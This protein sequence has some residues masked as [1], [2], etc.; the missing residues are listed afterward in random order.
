[1]KTSHISG[2][3]RSRPLNIIT[4]A[5]FSALIL[6]GCA[7]VEGDTT[8]DPYENVNRKVF[9]FNND[10]DN[11]LFE[12]VSRAY[13]DHVPERLRTV[14]HS[15]LKFLKTPMIFANN[16]LQGDVD[17][18]GL[19]LSRFITNG[20]MGFGGMVDA[21]SSMG[22]PY[23]E[24]DFGQTLAV[25]GMDEGPYLMI[26]LL[27]PTNIRDG[28]GS[29]VDSFLDPLGSQV[30]KTSINWSRRVV[31]G[32]DTRSDLLDT[33]EDLERTS[34]DYY[35]AIRS[36]YRQRRNDEISNGAADAP[37]PVPNISFD[38]EEKLEPTAKDEL[39]P[40]MGFGEEKTTLGAQTSLRSVK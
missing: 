31:G 16:V 17:R 1:M 13:V 12:P 21:A 10:L 33:L 19:T 22:A 24:E 14:V 23:H 5:A 26:P 4:A 32:V 2:Q 8:N 7:T 18:A 20:T 28:I 34:L 40:V 30:D 39:K 15:T 38:D 25:W 29:V 3:A 36:L 11:N 6:S 37:V 9:E 35:A 27:G